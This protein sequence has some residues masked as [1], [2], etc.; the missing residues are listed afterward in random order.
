[1]KQTFSFHGHDCCRTAFKQ[2]IGSPTP[3]ASSPDLSLVYLPIHLSTNIVAN[4][5]PKIRTDTKSATVTLKLLSVLAVK[6]KH[7]WVWKCFFLI[8]KMFGFVW[9]NLKVALEKA[10]SLG[11]SRQSRYLVGPRRD[12]VSHPTAVAV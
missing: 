11:H 12:D 2:H 5:A 6:N 1:M 10:E 3:F 7:H 9:R 4:S 8:S